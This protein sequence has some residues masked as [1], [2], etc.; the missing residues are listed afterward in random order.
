MAEVGAVAQS[1]REALRIFD[2]VALMEANTA[3]TYVAGAKHSVSEGDVIRAGFETYTVAASGAVDQDTS[4]S[5]GVKLYR[6][7]N[8]LTTFG[9][10]ATAAEL[11]KLDGVTAG[12][13]ELN[14]LD[15]VT[16]TTAEINYLDGVDEAR[17]TKGGKEF[18]ASYDVSAAADQPITGFD[19]TKFDA[20]EIEVA[21]L[22]P[23]TDNV[24]LLIQTSANGGVGY[25]T[26]ASDYAYSYTTAN[27]VPAQSGAGA[28]GAS[29]IQTAAAIG[30][31]ASEDGIS[32]TIKIHGP[33]LAKKTQVTWHLVGELESGE[34]C[35]F[36]GGGVRHSA[37]AVDAV[38]L[39]FSSGN[40]ESGT[41]TVY[42]LRNS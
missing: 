41:V 34:F 9:V 22:I 32:G 26:N 12:T 13:D 8:A 38:R 25:D 15:G 36:V 21:N 6:T 11:N 24:A 20:Y 17:I 28:N 2:T 29:S 14:I 35:S 23:A 40:I 39:K 1:V 10:T 5:G 4:T 30:S 18:I 16:A 31:D 19:A 3:L 33:H 27:T 7:S 37:A 42:G